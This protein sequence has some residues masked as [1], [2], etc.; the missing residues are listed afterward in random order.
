MMISG[1][2]DRSVWDIT[3][4]AAWSSGQ[5]SR[6]TSKVKR[7]E[8]P[9]ERIA[10]ILKQYDTN[11]AGFKILRVRELGDIEGAVHGGRWRY[12]PETEDYVATKET[13]VVI[14]IGGKT[15]GAM[16]FKEFRLMDTDIKDAVFVELLDSHSRSAGAAAVVLVENWPIRKTFNDDLCFYFVIFDTIWVRPNAKAANIWH[17]LAQ[18]VMARRYKRDFSLI[19]LQPFPLEYEAMGH[20]DGDAELAFSQRLKAMERLYAQRLGAEKPRSTTSESWMYIPLEL[21]LPP[22]SKRLRKWIS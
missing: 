6:I 16:I 8:A 10:N 21:S 1:D 15:E 11:S 9:P 22:P 5:D 2:D 18:Q 17:H 14:R 12:V 3:Q 13:S 4:L 7:G 20:R 19:L